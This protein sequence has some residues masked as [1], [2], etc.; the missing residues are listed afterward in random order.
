MP[1]AATHT[2]S[3]QMVKQDETSRSWITD[4]LANIILEAF[5][6]GEQKGK[7]KFLDSLMEQY[8]KEYEQAMD[9]YKE[10]FD[11][12]LAAKILC[13]SIHLRFGSP[14]C[15]EA[16]FI[17]PAKAYFGENFAKALNLS[18]N[19]KH[20]LSHITLNYRFMPFSETINYSVLESDGFATSYGIK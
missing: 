15:Y 11:V 3:K 20:P 7:K 5:R 10:F 2:H 4:D 1:A 14:N 8:T 18:K 17:I 13:H 9:V 19:F 6:D 16:I 12:L